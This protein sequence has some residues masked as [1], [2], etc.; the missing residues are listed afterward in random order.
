[1]DESKYRIIKHYY[2]EQP[3]KLNYFTAEYKLFGIWFKICSNFRLSLFDTRCCRSYSPQE[4]KQ[5]IDTYKNNSLRKK[6]KK[7]K[8]TEKYLAY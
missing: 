4:A 6:L 2:F 7:Q 3:F 5:R 8:K 1:M